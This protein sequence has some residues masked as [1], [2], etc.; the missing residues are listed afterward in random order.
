MIR[1]R[2][3]KENHIS[4]LAFEIALTFVLTF[5]AAGIV[6]FYSAGKSLLKS[7]KSI[8]NYFFHQQSTAN[9]PSLLSC[10]LIQFCAV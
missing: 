9:D 8:N 5:V 7:K 4:Y 10:Q 6:V 2:T 1:S 3:Y